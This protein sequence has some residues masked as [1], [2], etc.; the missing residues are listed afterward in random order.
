MV[1]NNRWARRFHA[2]VY[3]LTAVL[4]FTGWWLNRGHEGQPSVLA[5][6]LNRP[7]TEIHR[8]AG[9]ALAAVIA[10]G[11]L[12][13]IRATLTF[14]R[15]TVRVNRGDGHWFLRWPGGALTGRFGPHKGHFDPGQRLANVAFVTV[16]GTLIASGVALTT[17]KGGPTFATMVKVHRYSTYALIPLVLGHLVPAVGILPGYRGV[18]RAMHGRGRVPVATAQRLWPAATPPPSATE[19][20]RVPEPSASDQERAPR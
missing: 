4:L 19:P 12:L 11:M 3:V 16:L 15:E 5:D 10:A 20:P 18:W 17:L 6:V 2:A 9:W 1:R 7:D 8:Q 14:L 13:G